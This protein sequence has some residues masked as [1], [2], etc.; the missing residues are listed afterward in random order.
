MTR[1]TAREIA[2]HLVYEMEFQDDLPNVLL[3]KVFE[4]EYYP[5]L[6]EETELYQEKPNAKQLSYI[7]NCV[8]GVFERKQELDALIERYAE[9]WKVRRISR[10][11][12]AVLRL[13]I[14]EILYV[15]DAPAGA[16]INEAV[17]IARRYEEEEKVSFINGV[18]GAFVRE[19]L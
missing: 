11:S 6:A 13:S 14:Y 10:V 9:G 4:E 2:M 12:L 19:N 5:R 15:E 1:T 17:E 18:L 16:V 8:Q 7:E 3:S